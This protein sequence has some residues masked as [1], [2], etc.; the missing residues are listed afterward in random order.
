MRTF[1]FKRFVFGGLFDAAAFVVELPAVIEAADALAFD[2]ADAHRD[3]AM[4]AQM[5]DQMRVAR[6]RRDR[7]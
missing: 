4:R 6:F 2:A 5:A 1:D 7:A 3:V